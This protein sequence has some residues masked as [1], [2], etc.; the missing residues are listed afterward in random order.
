MKLDKFIIKGNF[1]GSFLFIIWKS[2]SVKY[3][4]GTIFSII[5]FEFSKLFISFT[6]S[7]KLFFCNILVV[8]INSL[9]VFSLVF[10]WI[11]FSS[12]SLISFCWARSFILFVLGLESDESVSLKPFSW[13]HELFIFW[14]FFYN[15]PFIEL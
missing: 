10:I 13:A 2:F 8:S 6:I 11:W 14:D 5:T 15:C 1:V 9:Q 4:E 3:P 7:S 12:F